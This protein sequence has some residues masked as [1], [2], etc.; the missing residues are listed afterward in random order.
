[1]NKRAWIIARRLPSNIAHTIF[2]SFLDVA[3]DDLYLML[4]LISSATTGVLCLLNSIGDPPAKVYGITHYGFKLLIL[5][6]FLLVCHPLSLQITRKDSLLNKSWEKSVEEADNI[7]AVQ[8]DTYLRA[9]GKPNKDG[10]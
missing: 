2:K 9:C 5:S 7:V 1:M 8:G 4:T 10:E 6:L 3:S